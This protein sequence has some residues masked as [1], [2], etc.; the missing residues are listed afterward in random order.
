MSANGDFIPRSQR[1][2]IN[3]DD[4][5]RMKTMERARPTEKSRMKVDFDRDMLLVGEKD[6][7]MVEMEKAI[8][9]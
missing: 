1:Q 8:P 9:K 6:A 2:G 5:E 3:D 7:A 4:P